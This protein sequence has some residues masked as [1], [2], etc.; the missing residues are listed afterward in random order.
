MDPYKMGEMEP[1]VFVMSSQT[2]AAVL[3]VTHGCSVSGSEVQGEKYFGS[4]RVYLDDDLSF[5]QVQ[6]MPESMALM[7]LQAKEKGVIN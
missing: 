4:V 1:D 5:N 7:I 6:K 2:W 3:D